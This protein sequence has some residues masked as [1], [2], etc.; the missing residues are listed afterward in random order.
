[1]TSLTAIFSYVK[2]IM[3]TFLGK[4]KQSDLIL[5]IQKDF[6]S[7]EIL[8]IEDVVYCK[9][10]KVTNRFIHHHIDFFFVIMEKSLFN[11]IIAHN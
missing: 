8:T 4:L 2:L 10:Q 5:D 9:W 11:L 1:M 7:N 3:N 6:I